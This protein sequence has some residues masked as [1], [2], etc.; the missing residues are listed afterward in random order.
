MATVNKW[1]V[2][3]PALVLFFLFR[4]LDHTFGGSDLMNPAQKYG[5][6]MFK[7]VFFVMATNFLSLFFETT[8][9]RYPGTT[10]KTKRFHAIRLWYII[11][12]MNLVACFLLLD[13]T[14]YWLLE[15]D[16]V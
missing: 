3:I 14:V 9:F 13:E 11:S 8:F 16:H 10:E 7:G 2:E 12:L 1:W 4:L 5:I 15:L 6:Y